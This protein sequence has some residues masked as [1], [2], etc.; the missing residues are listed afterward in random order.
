MI[1]DVGKQ[2]G[3]FATRLH[4]HPVAIQAERRRAEPDRTIRFEDEIPRPQILEGFLDFSIGVEIGFTRID[5]E[6]DSHAFKG[7][8]DA[9]KDALCG[10]GS[11]Q[12]V[13]GFVDQGFSVLGAKRFRDLGD[14]T[15]LIAVAGKDDGQTVDGLGPA[16]LWVGKRIHGRRRGASQLFQV[17]GANGFTENPHLPAGVVEVVL[18]LHPIAAG[19]QQ[20]RNAV[21]EHSLTTVAQGERAGRIGRDEFDLHPAIRAGV[22]VAVPRSGREHLGQQLV[23]AGPAQ[24]D[25]DESGAGD[26]RALDQPGTDAEFR[27]DALGD[28]AR[29]LSELPGEQHR[30][31]TREIAVIGVAGCLEGKRGDLVIGPEDALEGTAEFLL[32]T[33]F[34]DRARIAVWRDFVKEIGDLSREHREGGPRFRRLAPTRDPRGS[35]ARSRR[36]RARA[37]RPRLSGER[38]RLRGARSALL[39]SPGHPGRGSRSRGPPLDPH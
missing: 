1:G 34:H 31:V 24:P 18:A 21:A 13:S 4:Q 6:G 3:G 7:P 20:T 2:I 17:A 26:L 15:P 10:H 25:I 16:G 36:D 30:G 22:T 35:P 11:E 33:F 29:R 23:P 32:K 12:T 5:V 38:S 14:I 39:S 19:F 37:D 8:T 27:D 28:L 9:R